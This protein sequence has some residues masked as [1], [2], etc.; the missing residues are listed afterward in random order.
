LCRSL[1]FQAIFSHPFT[2]TVITSLIP[3]GAPE[4]QQ[5]QAR[6]LLTILTRANRPN[7]LIFIFHRVNEALRDIQRA[8]PFAMRHSTTYNANRLSM[9][10]RGYHP[11]GKKS[12]ISNVVVF[13][14][15]TYANNSTAS[16]ARQ[17]IRSRNLSTLVRVTENAS[18]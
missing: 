5:Q 8:Q 15:S 17:G 18:Q 1:A 2:P 7:G 4:T 11:H 16:D 10:R 3:Q 9:K 12:R 6:V 13:W 14:I